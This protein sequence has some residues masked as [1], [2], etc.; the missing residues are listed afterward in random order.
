MAKLTERGLKALAKTPGRH[1][2]GDSA[3]YLWVR[4]PTARY[5][6][7]RYRLGG[8]QTEL[9]LGPYPEVTLDEA[10]AQ[11]AQKHA[12]VANGADPIALKRP[13]PGQG[14]RGDGRAHL[15][16]DRRPL[17]RESQ[18]RMAQL[19]SS[20][21]VGR[22]HRPGQLLRADPQRPDRQAH[23]RDDPRPA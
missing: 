22:H 4:S 16:R 18:G 19:P 17:Y 13:T 11:H 15:R 12:M 14:A 10:R 8:R 23:D 1:R 5:W 20:P 3:L 6:T 7:Y 9:G 2:D 21:P